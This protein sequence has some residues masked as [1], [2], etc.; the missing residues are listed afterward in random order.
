MAFAITCPSAASSSTIPGWRGRP[1]RTAPASPPNPWAG[2]S[3]TPIPAEAGGGEARVWPAAACLVGASAVRCL[4]TGVRRSRAADRGKAW[5]AGEWRPHSSSFRTAKFV[6]KASRMAWTLGSS[7]QPQDSSSTAP[8]RTAN[9]SFDW[10][11][12][13]TQGRVSGSSFQPRATS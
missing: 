5:L 9:F 12:S 7:F 1:A 6:S 10:A 8:K 13:L 2:L 11:L 3:A 4:P